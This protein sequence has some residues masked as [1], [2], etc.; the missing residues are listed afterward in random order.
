[1]KNFSLYNTKG[2]INSHNWW[3]EILVNYGIIIFTGYIIFYFSLILKLGKI[4]YRKISSKKKTICEGLLISL[5]GFSFASL[6]PGSIMAFK[7]HWLL[8]A[9][10]LSF[11]N[12][13][14]IQEETQV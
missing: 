4:Y 3:L 13:I 9:F 8:F 2:F 1:M 6:G 10:S 12:Y 5:V 11:L 14:L 7:P